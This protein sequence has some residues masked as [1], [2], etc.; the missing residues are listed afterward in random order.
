MRNVLVI[1][2]KEYVDLYSNFMVLIVLLAY[3]VFIVYHIYLFGITLHSTSGV[4]LLFYDNLGNAAANYV[5]NT[6]TWVSTLVGIIIGCSMISS[7]R[8]GNAINTLIAKPVNR[9]SIINGKIIGSLAFL[10]S[11]QIIVIAL[12]TAGYLFLYGNDVDPYLYD[13]LC[14]LP[15]IFLFAMVYV[16]VFLSA[17]MLISLIVKDQAFAMILSLLTV[18]ISD[19]LWHTNV[20]L[21]VDKIF[22]GNGLGALC[23]YLSPR[24]SL[25]QI[26]RDFFDVSKGAFDAF[27]QIMP[28]LLKFFIYAIIALLLSYVIFIRRDIS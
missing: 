25:I 9:I 11:I 2:R 14:R 6:L 21:N 7:E 20:A 18:Y 4:Q 26:Q 28:E 3:F 17:S 1:A 23:V 8:I 19:V 24:G 27:Q 16:M 15:F 13:Y 10:A 12:F 5:F 22:P